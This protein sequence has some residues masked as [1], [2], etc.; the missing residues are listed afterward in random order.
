MQQPKTES[1]AELITIVLI[2][3]KGH[4]TY[5]LENIEILMQLIFFLAL[6]K[7]LH[8]HRYM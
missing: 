3:W 4:V 6:F 8:F 5:K 2:S 1:L 7:A